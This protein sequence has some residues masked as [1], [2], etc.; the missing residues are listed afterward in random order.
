MIEDAAQ[1]RV[2][3]STTSHLADFDHK[4]QRGQSWGCGSSHT[5]RSRGNSFWCH[6][7]RTRIKYRC[8]RSK[9][10]HRKAVA[11]NQSHLHRVS[12]EEPTIDV[13]SSAFPHLPDCAPQSQRASSSVPSSVGD[14][15]AGSPSHDLG[16]SFSWPLSLSPLS[17]PSAGFLFPS[18]LVLW[19]GQLRGRSLHEQSCSGCAS[20]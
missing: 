4:F 9:N 20:S 7:R 5:P 17:R 15:P 12:N 14:R 2:S 19:P 16:S 3:K 11:T 8:A 18:F 13:L 10:S 1:C 6:K